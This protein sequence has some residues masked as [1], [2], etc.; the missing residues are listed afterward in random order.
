M[1]VKPI[2]PGPEIY[3]ATVKMVRGT[4]PGV[5]GYHPA[6]IREYPVLT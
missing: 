4:N 5:E 3:I 1:K 6:G 2:A